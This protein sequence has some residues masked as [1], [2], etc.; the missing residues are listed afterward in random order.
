MPLVVQRLEH[1]LSARGLDTERVL[2]TDTDVIFASDFTV[3][4]QV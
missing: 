1:E 4:D 2:Y 3:P